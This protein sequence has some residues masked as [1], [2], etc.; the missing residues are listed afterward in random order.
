MQWAIPEVAQEVP[1]AS[2]VA[3]RIGEVV[4]CAGQGM[5]LGEDEKVSEELRFFLVY[6]GLQAFAE[7]AALCGPRQR[8]FYDLTG[9]RGRLCLAAS[10]LMEWTR[11]VSLE[12]SKEARSSAKALFDARAR[13]RFDATV[14]D[15]KCEVTFEIL[16]DRRLW[17]SDWHDADVAVFDASVFANWIDEGLLIADVLRRGIARANAGTYVLLI[18]SDVSL[19]DD[20]DDRWGLL[21]A[22]TTGS[23]DCILVDS[24]VVR[25]TGIV[26]RGDLLMVTGESSHLSGSR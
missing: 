14:F 26:L 10:A 23:A 4:R 18:V 19:D 15:G 24:H 1:R 17:Q 16:D 5:L 12:G 11:C 22:T 20:D 2:R 9:S 8:T 7:R 3:R 6:A 21:S 13:V 25:A